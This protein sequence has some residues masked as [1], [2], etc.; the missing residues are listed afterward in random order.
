MEILLGPET[1]DVTSGQ[2]P[3]ESREETEAGRESMYQRDCT[4]FY[5]RAWETAPWRKHRA[6]HHKSGSLLFGF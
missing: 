3:S 2:S 5:P 4:Q 6:S 1:T